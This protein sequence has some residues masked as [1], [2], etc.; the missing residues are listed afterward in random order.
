MR[1]ERITGLALW[2]L[3]C[4]PVALSAVLDGGGAWW[5]P[6]AGVVVLGAAAAL[7]RARPLTALLLA[8][9]LALTVTPRLWSPEYA[10]ALVVFG[11]L[12]GRR[13]A[14]ARPALHLFAGTAAGGLLILQAAHRDLWT[15]LVQLSTLAFAVM[16]PWLLGRYVRQYAQLVDTGWLLAGRL[17][18]EQRVTADRARLLERSRIAGD[19]HDSLGHDLSLI[20]LRAAAL[21]VDPSLSG[22]QQRDAGE[23][24][25]AAGDATDRLRDII[26]VLRENDGAAPASPPGETVAEQVGRARES[27][28]DVELSGEGPAD[29]LAPMTG[30]AVHRTVQE[31]LTN[32]ARHAP[33]APVTVRLVRSG[34]EL[35]VTVTSAALPPARGGPAPDVDLPGG[36]GGGT[37]LVGLDERVRLAGGVLRHGPLPGGG[38]EVSAT[39]PR[40]PG[41]PTAIA[42]EHL[43]SADELAWERKQ[44]RRRLKQAVWVPL[45]AT[46]AIGL[47]IGA[48]ALLTRYESVLGRARYDLIRVGDSAASVGDRLPGHTMGGAPGGAPPAPAGQECRYYRAGPFSGLPAYR[49]CFSGGA[50]TSKAVLR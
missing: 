11:Y 36:A 44:V 1:K 5:R 40:T 9:A 33:G 17:E 21:E 15:W 22:K 26:G 16:V 28:M 35:T 18:R 30:R 38:F 42:P 49:L 4:A 31:S 20:A 47:L 29:G 19:M 10:A 32:A 45:A 12:A 14:L 24:R 8:V 6:V 2:A 34:A 43:S 50:L 3:V 13:T 39:L 41:P 27:G 46:A 25:A 37:G 7:S 48:V 23:L